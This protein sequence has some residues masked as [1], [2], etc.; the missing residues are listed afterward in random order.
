MRADFIV[1][2]LVVTCWDSMEAI[3]AFAGPDPDVAV[4]PEKVQEMM[5]EY[6]RFAGHYEVVEH[7]RVGVGN[8]SPIRQEAMS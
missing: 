8:E 5:V 7:D 6:D 4:V 1:E 2:F 3:E